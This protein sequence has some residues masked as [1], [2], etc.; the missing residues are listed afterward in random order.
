MFDW[1]N[2]A[3][4]LVIS[5][6]VFPFYFSEQIDDSFSLGKMT[7]SDDA[8]YSYSITVAYL[9]LIITIPLLSGMA[10]SGG[11]RRR[12]MKLFT[13]IGG[14]AC[15]SLFFFTGHDGLWLGVAGFALANIG[16]G[17]SLVFYNSFLPLIAKD[18][19]MDQ[20]SARGFVLG[21]IGSVLLLIVCLV[22]ILKGPDWGIED[23][24]L[25]ARISFLLV[26]VWW[27]AWAQY[28]FRRL[29]EEQQADSQKGLMAKGLQE[30]RHVITKLKS[31]VATRRFLVSF[32]FYNAGVQTVLYLAGT[33][34]EKE[35]AF[36][37]D[38]LILL[39]L[40][41]QLFGA[42]GAWAFAKLSERLGNKVT[43]LILVSL[44]TAVCV[45]AYMT[46]DKWKF[47]LLA[48]LVGL[49]M[50]GIQALSRATYGKLIDK[51]PE[52]SA[53][54]FSFYNVMYYLSIMMGTFIFGLLSQWT[55]SMRYSILAL[56]GLFVIGAL[57]LSRVHIVPSGNQET[58]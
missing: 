46:H 35:L 45:L 29:P 2:S 9:I 21:Y 47:Y 17:G 3:F 36:E 51:H 34:A 1:A 5:A 43:L 49:T 24:G 7:I 23:P 32:L 25:P 56:G 26:G 31:M 57:L 53:S 28:S 30:L 39:I 50:G 14:L 33:F 38:E 52:D 27:I 42:L 13:Y 12:F 48:V 37:A 4:A 58:L 16:F 6:A 40:A 10:D 22:L 8:I 44:W 19:E 20:L 11:M 54:F 15:I 55:G 18:K 41:L